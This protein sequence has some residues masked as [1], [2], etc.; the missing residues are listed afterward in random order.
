MNEQFARQAQA[1]F[2]DVADTKVPAEMQAIAQEGI[3]KARD[4]FATWN[5]A[6]L[7]GTRAINDV[8]LA[9]Q[10]G[11]DTVG[12]AVLKNAHAA[13]EAAF[14]AA[15]GVARAKTLPEVAQLQMKFAQNQLALANQHG[16][17]LFELSAKIARETTEAFTAIAAKAAGDIQKQGELGLRPA[18]SV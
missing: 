14:D 13:A 12:D 11:A 5:D 6:V 7:S 1:F 16:K 3:A 9:S 2:A 8:M 17:S 10:S 18:T 15:Q 4:A